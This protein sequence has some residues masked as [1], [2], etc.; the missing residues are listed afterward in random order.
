MPKPHRRTASVP[1][2]PR[3]DGND[4]FVKRVGPGRKC[5]ESTTTTVDDVR[6]PVKRGVQYKGREQIGELEQKKLRRFVPEPHNHGI[7][8]VGHNYPRTPDVQRFAEVSGHRVEVD[9]CQTRGIA[10]Q[11]AALRGYHSKVVRQG[12]PDTPERVPTKRLTD[13]SFAESNLW[14][15][16]TGKTMPAFQKTL[17]RRTCRSMPPTTTREGEVTGPPYPRTGRGRAH[18]I[19]TDVGAAGKFDGYPSSNRAQSPRGIRTGIAAT[20]PAPEDRSHRR[21]LR[22]AESFQSSG[23]SPSPRLGRAHTPMAQPTGGKKYST[24]I[25]QQTPNT[26]FGGIGDI[27]AQ[28]KIIQRQASTPRG[29]SIISWT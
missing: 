24:T 21:V 16:G 3:N 18:L 29:L 4:K 8:N 12:F 25:I 14:P 9:D 2:G 20:T 6:V 10:V 23:V 22:P 7:D 28:P 1:L 5:W 15:V 17:G 26:R 11:K 27:P 13:Q 19:T